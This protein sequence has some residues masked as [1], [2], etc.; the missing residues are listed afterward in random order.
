MKISIGLFLSFF[1]FCLFAQDIVI[2]EVLYDPESTDSGYEW[3]ELYNYSDISV[4]L[5]SWK[6][7]KAGSEF[8]TVLTFDQFG[9][10]IIYPNSFFLIGEEFVLNVDLTANLAFQNGGSETDG[11][12]LVSP[13][14]LYTDTVLYD[15]PNSNNLPDDLFNPGVYFAPDVSSGNT[16]ARITDGEDSNNCEVDFFECNQ[17]TPGETNFYPID[18]AICN[19]ETY[20]NQGNYW[21]QMEIENLSV[22]N[23]DNSA[24]SLEVYINNQLTNT[25]QLPAIPAETTI[26]FTCQIAEL[27]G[28]YNQ[29]EVELIY[30]NDN[31]LDNNVAHCSFL[32]GDSPFVINEIMFKPLTTN[33]EW[34]EI[35][36]RT[37]CAYN[38]D[39]LRITDASGGTID[40]SGSF[41]AEEYIIVC[42]DS[43]L[44]MQT[45]PACIPENVILASGWTSLNNT[46][47]TL[48]LKDE[49]ATQFDSTSYN[50]N[51][52][53]SDFSIERIDPFD[54]ENISWD[55]CFDSLGTPT[56]A[57]SVLPLQYDL[58]LMYLDMEISENNIEH[59][60]IINNE[61][62]DNISEVTVNSTLICNGE[63]PGE[64]IFT[65]DLSFEDSLVY[66]F[67][68]PVP[69]NGYYSFLYEISSENDLNSENNS[70][71]SFYNNSAFP[72]VINEIMYDPEGDEPEWIEIINNFII[73]NAAEIVIVVD[74]DTLQ[75]PYCPEQYYLITGSES[76]MVA[77]KHKYNIEHVTVLT[78]LQSLSNN[79]ENMIVSDLF[80]NYI[81]EFFYCPEWNDNLDGVSIE[82][83]NS[84]IA[85]DSRNWG[86]STSGCT[87]GRANSIF[88]E[89]LPNTMKLK[90]SPN[91]FS[92]YR[93]ERTV[94]SFSLPEIL[95]T[96]TLRIFDL[97]GRMVRRL[98]DQVLQASEGNIIWDGRNDDGTKLPVGIYIIL[99]QATARDSEKVYSK[100]ITTVIGK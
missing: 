33:Q 94:F 82:R 30:F 55:V 31:E 49:F 27:T 91:P 8:E 51:S 72:F 43:I 66:S 41:P 80:D 90:V 20:E 88:V 81:E 54:D 95:S 75:L 93:E 59:S 46:D 18:L 7:E 67:N 60:I 35:F 57:N 52:C 89:V 100:K 6:I 45:Y 34:V 11:I 68:S 29:I 5:A 97:K 25:Y 10:N 37:D 12:R 23:V 26:E 42:Q 1:V 87:P 21:L 69:Q 62:L 16:L 96:V 63:Y 13:D 98:V 76:D 24:A 83:V 22:E 53:P 85:P 9:N 39:N 38:V 99:M 84:Q 19:L 78:G 2:N 3:I 14:T 70:A 56:Y 73:P 15:S 32:N 77:L 79:G 36:N 92:P 86:P 44:F 74:D 58:S 4:D 65:D 47:E 71:F 50:G 61:G 28:I 64:N 17:P 48:C 40:F